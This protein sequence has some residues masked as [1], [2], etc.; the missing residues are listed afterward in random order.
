[1]R[2]PIWHITAATAPLLVLVAGC[3]RPAATTAP[4]NEPQAGAEP[5]VRVVKP[6]RRTVRHPIEQPG[7][8][9]EAF[10][11]TPLYAKITGYVT[12]WD[13]KYDI[14]KSVRGGEVLCELYVPEMAVQVQQKQA[15]VRRADAQ[16]RQAEAAVLSAQAQLE[17]SK[18]QYE[19]LSRAGQTVLAGE[20]IDE[21]RLGYQA[22]QAG[23]VKAKADV[24]FAKAQLAVAEADRDYAQ[25]MLQYA[26]IQAPFEGVITQRHVNNKDFVQPAGTGPKGL[27]LFVVDQLDPVRV[28]VNVPTA[29]APW[30]RDGDPVSLRLEGAGGELILGQVT[31]NARAL[32]PQTRT[33]RTEIDLPNPKQKLLPGMYVQATITVQH[34]NVWTLPEAA[35]VTEG[36]Q[37]LCYRLDGGKAVRTSLQVGLRGGGLVEVVKK[38]LKPAMAGEEGP[39]VAIKGDEAII[40][41]DPA[42]LHDG[43]AV[44]VQSQ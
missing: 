21:T 38:Q 34:A 19:R 30:I 25:T 41:N 9:I 20:S 24:A 4:G 37:T 42:L 7:F 35:V 16:I 10:Q 8:N 28:F 13:P 2:Q 31:R 26:K 3:N 18:S 32:D 33:L 5:V 12:K 40:A 11:E 23:L 29:D 27:P 1:M 36:N 17:R 39:W 15:A 43:Q 22:A 44:H 14:G 6:A